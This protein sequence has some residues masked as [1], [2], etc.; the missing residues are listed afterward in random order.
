[1]LLA[2]ERKDL[3][4]EFSVVLAGQADFRP[5]CLTI[6]G[7]EATEMLRRIPLNVVHADQ[8]AAHVVGYCL[9]SRWSLQPSLLELLLGYLVA[10]KGVGGLVPIRDRVHDGNDPNPDPYQAAWLEKVHPFFDRVDLRDSVRK[11]VQQNA[12]PLLR[13]A[14]PPGSYGRNYT[15]RLLYHLATLP[16][17]NVRVLEAKIGKGNGPSY[18]LV[19]LAGTLAAQMGVT[20]TPPSNTGSF[21]PKELCRW[22]LRHVMADPRRSIIVLHGFGQSG[23]NKEVHEMIQE[24]AVMATIGD[25]RSRLRIVLPGY[26]EPLPQVSSADILEETVPATTRVTDMDLRPCLDEWDA[27]RKAA[28]KA[29]IEAG[30]ISDIAAGIIQDAPENGK[31]R[32]E[33]LNSRLRGL[34]DLP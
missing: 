7:P 24:I 29:G 14:L 3:E 4:L 31:S 16:S 12:R 22:V 6:F 5:L 19:D 8:F 1:M 10:T 34:L 26:S 27:M 9:E 30:K 18:Q 25:F 23:V 33:Y 32:L 17:L 2:E 28:G 20:E 11:L 21:D 15:S 13:I